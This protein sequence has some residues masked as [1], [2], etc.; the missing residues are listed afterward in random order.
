MLLSYEVTL[1]D[2]VQELLSLIVLLIFDSNVPL[3]FK[4]AFSVTAYG[5]CC[6]KAQHV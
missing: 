6:H 2:Y 5:A 4:R 1:V 3:C